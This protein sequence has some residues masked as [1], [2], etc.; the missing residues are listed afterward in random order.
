[1]SKDFNWDDDELALVKGFED[2]AIYLNHHGHVVI[3]RREAMYEDGDSFVS[4]PR[5]CADEVIS[6]IRALVEEG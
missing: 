1:M 5:K 6:A 4:F 2:I 3:H